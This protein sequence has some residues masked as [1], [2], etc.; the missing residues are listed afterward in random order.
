MNNDTVQTKHLELRHVKQERP[1]ST[2][3]QG[4]LCNHRADRQADRQTDSGDHR[5]NTSG[6]EPMGEP[7]SSAYRPGERDRERERDREIERERGGREAVS[8]A[9]TVILQRGNKEKKGLLGKGRAQRE[10]KR[11]GERLGRLDTPGA[12]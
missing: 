5:L 4:Y 8:A 12:D 1:C 7:A 9:R 10:E 6:F 3:T 11:S 2:M